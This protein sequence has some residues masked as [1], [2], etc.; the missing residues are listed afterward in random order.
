MFRSIIGFAILAVAAWLGLKLIFGILGSLMGLAFT[1]L[2]LG[3]IGF[4]CYLV[5]RVISPSTAN[6]IRDVIKGRP[7]DA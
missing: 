6:K 5:L 7:A 3:A 2:Y 4:L 1:I